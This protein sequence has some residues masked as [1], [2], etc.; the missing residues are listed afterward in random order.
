MHHPATGSAEPPRGRRRDGYV[1]GVAKKSWGDLSPTQRKVVV[2]GGAVEA[3]LTGYCLW[4]L[5]RR[6]DGQVRGSKALWRPA[7]FVQP[8]GPLAYLAAGR[9]G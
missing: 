7:L 9:R 2:V 3:A 4:D 8:V 5:S 1:R 6:P